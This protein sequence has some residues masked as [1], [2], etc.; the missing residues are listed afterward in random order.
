MSNFQNNSMEYLKAW[1]Q[2]ESKSKQIKSLGSIILAKLFSFSL[3]DKC[4]IIL[5]FLLLFIF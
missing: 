5:L 4:N 1:R 3:K 2:L